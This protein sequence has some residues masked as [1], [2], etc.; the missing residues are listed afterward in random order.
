MAYGS[1]SDASVSWTAPTVL[2]Q[3]PITNYTVQYRSSSG[4]AW[5][6][7]TRAAST[8]TSATV[9]GQGVSGYQFRVSAT[10]GAGTGAYS[11]AATI[12]S[13][14]L[15]TYA[16]KYGSGS[17]TVTGTSTITATITGGS[18]DGDTRLWLLVGATGTL[19]Y[20]VTASSEGGADGGRLYLTSASP[21]QHSGGNSPFDISTITG[22][23]NVSAAVSGTGNSSGT[24]S[25]TAGQYV[26]L[27]YYKDSSVTEGTDTITATLSIA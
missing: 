8:A 11:S 13:S 1:G 20:S 23:T 9:T 21:A 4:A 6:T 2:S 10:N 25:V 16:N 24:L 14:A 17:H 18:L 7:F 26:V 22:L 27:R 5:A 12:A 19:S 15:V 3:T